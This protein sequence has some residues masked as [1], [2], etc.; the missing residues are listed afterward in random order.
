MEE[1]AEVEGESEAKT[2]GEKEEVG[3]PTNFERSM[4]NDMIDCCSEKTT[5]NHSNPEFWIKME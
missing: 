5:S 4:S 2:E 1:E 3:V